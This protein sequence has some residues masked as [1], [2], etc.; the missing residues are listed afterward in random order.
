MTMTT[1]AEI[2][3]D[4]IV[5]NVIV[6]DA[7]FVASQT[8]KTYIEYDETNPAGIGYTYDPETGLF[9]APPQPQPVEPIEPDDEQ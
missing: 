8:D 6:A 3:D 9:T 1:Y 4:N 5:V 2:N 7:D